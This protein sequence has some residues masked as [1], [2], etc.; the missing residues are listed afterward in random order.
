MVL[1]VLV[2]NKVQRVLME[3]VAKKERKVLTVLL[4]L[5]VPK[6][7]MAKKERKVLAVLKV[8]AVKKEKTDSL[9]SAESMLL[10]NNT[11]I[12]FLAMTTPK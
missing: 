3:I 10:P 8:L 11:L 1:A 4:A 12:P 7:I 9:N 5:A 2:V 6:E